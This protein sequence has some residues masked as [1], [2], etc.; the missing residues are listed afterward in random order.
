[1]VRAI[2]GPAAAFLRNGKALLSVCVFLLAGVFGSSAQEKGYTNGLVVSAHPEASKVGLNILKKGGNAVDAAVAVQFALAVVYP[3]AGNIGGGGFM[4]IRQANG[5]FAS[6]DFRETAP[7]KA[8]R[9]MYLDRNGKVIDGLSLT[10]HLAAGV[11]GTVAGMAE[12]HEKY[13]KLPW[14]EVV[15]PAVELAYKGFPITEAQARQ[16]NAYQ[17]EFRENNPGSG[18]FLRKNWDAGD[19]LLQEHLAQTLERIRDKGSGGFYR[20]RTARLIVREMKEGGGIIRSADLKHYKAVWREPV[21]GTYKDYKVISM[22]P[23]S[24]GGIALLQLLKMVEPYALR[25][26]GHNGS[27]AV[28]LMAEAERRVYADR[29]AYLGDPDF[30]EVPAQALLDSVYLAKRMRPYDP[31]EATPSSEITAGKTGSV[32]ALN[33]ESPQTTHFSITDKEGKAVAVTTTL[34]GNFGCKVF[35]D[36]AGFLLNNEMDDFS[37]KPGVPNMFGLVG[38]EANAIEPGKRMLSSMTPAILEK[39]GE[40]FMVLGSPGGATIITTVFQTILNAITYGMDIREAVKAKRFHHQWLPDRILAEEGAFD[41]SVLS[42]LKSKGHKIDFT[43]SIGRCDAI[44]IEG[45]RYYGGA[46]PRGDDTAAG[47]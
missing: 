28:H 40:L 13:G 29:A 21:T 37:S 39:D 15:S 27:E 45:G 7:G 36:E 35:V 18:Y 34:N 9:D 31:E 2:V 6:L 17:D 24:S 16:F 14:R 38:G 8:H 30:Y 33:A 20:G 4:V 42:D 41:E 11:P 10:G 12:A 3:N 5:D 19:L 25:G 44:L 1:M 43:G 47:Y 26:M 46:D 23:P 32:Q 22:P